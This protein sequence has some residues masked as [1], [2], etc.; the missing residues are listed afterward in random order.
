MIRKY[1]LLAM[2]ASSLVAVAQTETSGRSLYHAEATKYNALDHTKLRVSLN[3]EKKELYGE[4]WLTASPY[5][6]PTDSLVLD[7]QAM[8]IH[9]VN[10]SDKKGTKGAPLTYKYADDKLTI[11]LNKTYQRGEKYTVY[12]KYTAQPEKVG[13]HGSLA[14]TDAKGLYFINSN[15]EDKE[16]PIQVWSQGETKANSCWFPTIDE[17][18]QK[19]TQ[20]M[21][22]T[23]PNQ[24]ITLSN[25]ILASS[26]KDGKGMRTDYWVMNKKHAPYLFFL[27]TGEYVE[28]K[29]KPWRGKVPISYYVEKEYANVAKR[30]FGKT[31]EMIE[32]YSKR[33]NYDFPW[34]KYHQITAQEYVSGAMENTTAVLHSSM[35]QQDA[36]ALNDQNIWEATVAHELFHHWFGDLV[37]AESWANLT[38]NESFANY[39]EYLWFEYKYGKDYADYHLYRDITGYKNSGSFEKDLVRFDYKGR[40]DMFDAV[41]YNKGGSILHMLRNYLGDKAF[42]EGISRY[43]KEHQYGTGEAH[44]L[45]LALEE[46]SGRDLNWFFNQWYFNHGNVVMTPKVTYDNTKKEAVLEITQD[47]KLMFQFP[48]EVDIYDGGKYVRKQVWVDAKAKNEFRFPVSASYSLINIDPRGLIVGDEADYKT[49]AQYLFQYKNAKD[50]KSRNQAVEYAV[51]AGN[52]DILLLALKDPFFRLRILAMQGLSQDRMNEWIPIVENLANNDPENLVKAAAITQ[53]SR[54]RDTKFRPLYEKSVKI[55]SRAIKVAAASGLVSLDPSLAGQYVDIID[56]NKLDRQQFMFFLPYILKSRNDKYLPVLANRVIYYPL[57]PEQYQAPFKEGFTWLMSTDNTELTKKVTK[58]LGNVFGWVS[59]DQKKQ[60]RKVAE[61]GLRI[62]EDL[63]KKNPNSASIKEQI[64][65]LKNI[66]W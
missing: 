36:E 15:K 31:S 9:S 33:L 34:Q 17:I 66:K 60:L 21:Y 61:E 12:I 40:E 14:I 51:N 50:F 46:V 22:I 25:G 6:Y 19:S 27:G 5:F 63:L 28:V 42:F 57:Y 54:T 44:Q 7:A 18:N 11:H 56:L 37:T 43:L 8:I 4:E 30:I 10:L 23:V 65:L 29:D 41:S 53:L 39:S 20:E 55:P 32:F 16:K 26:I 48:L 24:F 3:F 49:P 35:A 47:E 52:T 13:K 59:E 62:K 64:E 58:T 2:F 45:R 38:V 1:L